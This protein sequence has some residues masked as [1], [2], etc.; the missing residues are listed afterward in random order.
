MAEKTTL[1]LDAKLRQRLKRV[2]LATGK[3][4]TDLVREGAE[5][6]VEAHE[7]QSPPQALRA[8]ADRAWEE[9]LRGLFRGKGGADRHDEI[10]YE[11]R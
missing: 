9:L 1:Y 10:L 11:D 4:M 5:R 8:R 7:R 2:A 6:V 3:T